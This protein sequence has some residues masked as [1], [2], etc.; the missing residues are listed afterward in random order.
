M[1]IKSASA[2]KTLL[3]SLRDD[4]D[5]STPDTQSPG[6]GGHNK[7]V[8]EVEARV[9]ASIKELGV[10]NSH[11]KSTD[12][13]DINSYFVDGAH[14]KVQCYVNYISKY[15]EDTWSSLVPDSV[16]YG[17]FCKIVSNYH[18]RF[19]KRR[20][21]VC[22][23]C[24]KLGGMIAD[25]RRMKS[26]APNPRRT[27]RPRS[28]G[29]RHD[30]F[31]PVPAGASKD[32]YQDIIDEAGKQLKAHQEEAS[33]TFT[34]RAKQIAKA[35]EDGSTSEVLQIDFAANLRCPYSEI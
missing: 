25:A 10:A 22:S 17:R 11:Y 15:E 21:D 34:L 27:Q 14:N 26:T 7:I 30:G 19:E 31:E 2:M 4:C 1:G 3:A 18:I 28:I 12:S 33:A 24:A 32:E 29:N 8:K 9:I 20:V 13:D 6:S 5:I 35:K 16:I 23:D